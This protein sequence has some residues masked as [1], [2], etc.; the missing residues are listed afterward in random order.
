MSVINLGSSCQITFFYSADK[1]AVKM[2][3]SDIQ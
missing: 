1:M 3:N 2:K